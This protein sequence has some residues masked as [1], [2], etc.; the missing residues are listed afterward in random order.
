VPDT[1][2]PTPD[3]L[4]SLSSLVDQS[5]LLRTGGDGTEPRFV[6]L[7]T[8]REFGLER[9]RA[10]GE[11]EAIRARHAGVFAALAEAT[12]PQLRGREQA[13]HLDRLDAEH[14]NL[15]AALGW[16]LGTPDGAER[17]LALAGS[18]HWFWY[19]RG[20]FSEGRRWLAAALAATSPADAPAAT[21]AAASAADQVAAAPAATTRA[22]SPARAKALVGV[23]LLASRQ[24]DYATARAA[25]REAIA[26]ARRLD[27]L[28]GLA[29]ALHFLAM[30]RLL[31]DDYLEMAALVADGVAAFRR[32]GDRWG[33][34]TALHALGM[35][36]LVTLRIDEAEAPFAESRR[37]YQALG[38][39]WGMARVLHYAG[40][41]ARQR[42]AFAVARERYE[43]ALALYGRLGHHFSAAIVL[44]NLGY[45]AQHQGNVRDGLAF[46][47]DGLRRHV[48]HGDR[49]N[50]AHCLGGVAGMRGRLGEPARA[51][52]GFG[53]AAALL[54]AVGV[55]VWPIDR[56]DYERNLAHARASLNAADFAA[57][58]EAG[59]AM[60]LAEA[61]AEA[62]APPAEVGTQPAAEAAGAGL[63]PR[64]LEV[65]RLVAAGRSDREIG[66]AL[67]IGRRTVETH[68]AAVLA[69][70]GAASRTEA[71]AIAVRRGLA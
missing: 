63:S 66:A 7:E 41:A 44:H 35:T 61:I 14:D 46:F 55:A 8:I 21:P 31:H 25:L 51:A 23:G 45:V 2:H 15:R 65:L 32:S 27:D 54:D 50:I 22:D 1:R 69:K 62:L 58:W 4:D 40:E 19:L 17:A 70:L 20:H 53:A 36:A 29:H 56:P 26:I 9:L 11:E 52:R 59:Q 5:L 71:A 28:S 38:D 60:P 18:L 24:D 34:A 68:V 37:L 6:M 3:T 47:A 39:E 43:R 64:Q 42:G 67:G 12:E 16:L 13:A 49:V 30:G 33:L 57:A 10:S 48:E